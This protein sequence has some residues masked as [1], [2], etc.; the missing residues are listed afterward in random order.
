M[1]RSTAMSAAHLC[2]RTG[3]KAQFRNGPGTKA[4]AIMHLHLT[5]IRNLPAGAFLPA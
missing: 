1:D 3:V 4:T 5:P 2:D